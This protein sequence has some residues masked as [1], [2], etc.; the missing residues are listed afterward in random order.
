[1]SALV[2]IGPMGAGKTSIGRRVAKALGLPFT[3]TDAA[4]VRAHGP[5]EHIFATHGEPHFRAVERDAVREALEA[6]GVVALGGGAILDPD[7]RV[8]LVDHRVVLLTVAPDTIAS[9]IRDTTRPL[10]QGEDA[11]ARWNEI[12]QARRSLYEEAADVTFDTSDGPLQEVVDAV[13]HWA[14]ATE[15]SKEHA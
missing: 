5:I 3:D 12:Y 2:L 7:T 11:V 4:I 9:R 8:A 10:L 1:M 6:G 14:A 15:S 13:A